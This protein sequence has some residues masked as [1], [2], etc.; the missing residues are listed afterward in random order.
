MSLPGPLNLLGR[1][2]HEL[3]LVCD[4][5]L[6]IREAN[7]L[8]IRTLRQPLLGQPLLQLIAPSARSKAVAFI[9]ELQQ[10]SADQ[11]TISWELLLHVPQDNPLLIGMRG[12]ALP[13]GG[14]LLMGGSE[15]G[16]ITRLYQEV[17]ALNSELTDLIRKLTREQA[18]LSAQVQRLLDHQEHHNVNTH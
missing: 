16:G 17:L 10:L 1:L 15:P 18:A 9:A 4:S 11:L 3:I 14:W 8:A 2:S 7:E 13:A 12:G 5:D 6:V